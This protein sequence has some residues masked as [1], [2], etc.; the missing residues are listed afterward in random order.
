MFM[1]F[2]HFCQLFCL[3]NISAVCFYFSFL[4]YSLIY[5]P[6]ALALAPLSSLLCYIDCCHN[7]L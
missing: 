7:A 5:L 4:N 1:W 2:R 6:V 3:S